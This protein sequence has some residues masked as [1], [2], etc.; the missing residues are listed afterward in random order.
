MS[1]EG[2]EVTEE[3]R[4]CEGLDASSDEADHGFGFGPDFG[5]ETV[6]DGGRRLRT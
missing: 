4:P 6:F 3:E 1:W 2:A 5:E